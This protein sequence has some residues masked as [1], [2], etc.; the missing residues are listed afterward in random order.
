MILPSTL[1]SHILTGGPNQNLPPQQLQNK[2]KWQSSIKTPRTI[3]PP[4]AAYEQLN[5]Q[6]GEVEGRTN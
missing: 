5:Q 4:K 1:S 2:T 6:V 3:K